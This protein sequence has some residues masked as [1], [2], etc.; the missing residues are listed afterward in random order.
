MLQLADLSLL[1]AELRS[2]SLRISSCLKQ[3][4][5][6]IERASSLLSSLEREPD[7]HE[8]MVSSDDTETEM[9]VLI[10]KPSFAHAM[11]IVHMVWTVAL[12][13]GAISRILPR[14]YLRPT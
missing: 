5:A 2:K 8:S 1:G 9:D 3:A 6:L 14:R 7:C 4:L 11:P 12:M 10:P 13:G